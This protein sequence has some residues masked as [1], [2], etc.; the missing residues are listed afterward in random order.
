V[1]VGAL[2]LDVKKCRTKRCSRDRLTWV[3]KPCWWCSGVGDAQPWAMPDVGCA[4]RP[5]PSNRAGAEP[6]PRY[7]RA[8]GVVVEAGGSIFSTCRSFPLR[9]FTCGSSSARWSVIAAASW[10][11]RKSLKPSL[12]RRH[13]SVRSVFGVFSSRTVRVSLAVGTT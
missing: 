5:V 4:K 9:G 13:T 8:A 6:T 3:A 2:V 12:T 10:V 7:V 11:R 1:C